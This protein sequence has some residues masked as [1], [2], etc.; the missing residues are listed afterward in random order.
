[1]ATYHRKDKRVKVTQKLKIELQSLISYACYDH[2]DV[3][4]GGKSMSQADIQKRMYHLY[5]PPANN[6]KSDRISMVE[7]FLTAKGR[8]EPLF[9][10]VEVLLDNNSSTDSKKLTLPPLFHYIPDTIISV[11]KQITLQML[12]SKTFAN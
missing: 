7:M 4:M 10:C 6:K 12:T 8:F 3:L 2:K 11:A 1:M 5:F 9:K